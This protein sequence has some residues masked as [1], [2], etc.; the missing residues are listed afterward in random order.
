[1]NDKKQKSKS[2]GHPTPYKKDY[3]E[4]AYKLCLLGFTDKELAVFFDVCE[5]TINN[6]KKA[7][8][9]FLESI[10][11]GK[12][13]TDADVALSLRKRAEGMKIVKTKKI[14][15]NGKQTGAIEVK[16]EDVPPDTRACEFWLRN[17]QGGLWADK[18]HVVL[19]DTLMDRFR[20]RQ[21]EKDGSDDN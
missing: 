13:L 19:E 9:E 10:R 11:K 4:Q 21:N 20:K 18:Q 17:R 2:P 16:E 14:V 6:W 5:A 15:M 1:M 12:A 7:N 3:S 8:P